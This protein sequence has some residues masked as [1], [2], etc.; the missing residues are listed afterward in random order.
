MSKFDFEGVVSKLKSIGVKLSTE[1]SPTG[2]A[3]AIADA[4]QIRNL[5]IKTLGKLD[6]LMNHHNFTIFLPAVGKG[7]GLARP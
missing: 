5:G 2:V 3:Y 4:S 1:R 7:R 6:Y